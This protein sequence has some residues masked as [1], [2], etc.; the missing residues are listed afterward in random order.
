MTGPVEH[1]AVG[2]PGAL[3]YGTGVAGHSTSLQVALSDSGAEVLAH[4]L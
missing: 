1:R 3:P 2:M 4:G